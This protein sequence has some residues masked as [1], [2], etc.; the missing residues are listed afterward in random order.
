MSAE[1]RAE[2]TTSRE[3]MLQWLVGLYVAD[4]AAS[5]AGHPTALDQLLEESGRRHASVRMGV[6]YEGAVFLGTKALHEDYVAS[7][8]NI[9]PFEP[10]ERVFAAAL[11]TDVY[12]E[13]T[14]TYPENAVLPFNVLVSERA[15]TE[16]LK[17]ET[18]PQEGLQAAA[19]TIEG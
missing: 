17:R 1:V 13:I 5:S 6:T 14:G 4:R 15:R 12:G 2:E 16:W 10:K 9:V 11:N 7:G 18:A 3:A 8:D 19:A